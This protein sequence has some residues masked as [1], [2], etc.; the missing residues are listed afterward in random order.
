MKSFYDLY[1][2]CTL[3]FKMI[4][5]IAKHLN[6]IEDE[7]FTNPDLPHEELEQYINDQKADVWGAICIKIK[8]LKFMRFIY[9]KHQ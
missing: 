8:H 3:A 1:Q 5:K 2:R 7:D 6:I 4:T 9:I